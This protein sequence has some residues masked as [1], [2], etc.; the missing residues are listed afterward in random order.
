MTDEV[1]EVATIETPLAEVV[2]EKKIVQEG[3]HER[4][5]QWVTAAER[6]P[7]EVIAWVEANI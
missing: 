6:F 2:E 4:L 5:S 1:E 3:F 7:A